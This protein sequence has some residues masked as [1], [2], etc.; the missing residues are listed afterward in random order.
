[1]SENNYRRLFLKKIFSV[2]GISLLPGSTHL[3]AESFSPSVA[4]DFVT[5]FPEPMTLEEYKNHKTDFEN[6]DKVTTLISVFKKSGKMLSE[7]F[8]FHGS[9]SVWTV[10]FKSES[11]FKEWMTITEELESHKDQEREVAGFRL[12]IRARS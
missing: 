1:M 11:H 3:V 4:I 2:A 12:E 7:K 5:H 9:Y 6:K 8:S 10:V